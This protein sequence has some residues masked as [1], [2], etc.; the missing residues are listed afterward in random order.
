M[1]RQDPNDPKSWSPKKGPRPG[2]QSS[3]PE[4]VLAEL[5]KII[6]G[7]AIS[8]AWDEDPNFRWDGDGPDPAEEGFVAYDVTVTARA[9]VAGEIVEGNDYLGGSYSKPGEHDPDVHGYFLQ[10]LDQALWELSSAT[11]EDPIPRIEDARK[12]VKAAMAHS[13]EKQRREIRQMEREARRR[14][15]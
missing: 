3:E 2:T 15:Q 6:P 14:Q 4:D 9:I 1:A 10:M 8:T 11:R 7:V 13:S 12:Y 5:K